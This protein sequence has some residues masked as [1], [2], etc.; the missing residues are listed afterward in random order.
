MQHKTPLASSMGV[1]PPLPTHFPRLC[2]PHRFAAACVFIVGLGG[3]RPFCI[4]MPGVCF[5][6]CTQIR[7]IET[8]D[9]R[10]EEEEYFYN[11][12]I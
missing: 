11:N 1:P 9:E 5:L 6:R 8:N 3:T 4:L 10:F 12:I 2:A 7:L